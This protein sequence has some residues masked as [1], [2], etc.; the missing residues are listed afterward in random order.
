MLNLEGNDISTVKHSRFMS[1]IENKKDFEQ[2]GHCCQQIT[3]PCLTDKENY[4]TPQKPKRAPRSTAAARSVANLN[5]E[6]KKDQLK[7]QTDSNELLFPCKKKARHKSDLQT[8]EHNEIIVEST[9][10]DNSLVYIE[11]IQLS[12]PIEF[13]EATSPILSLKENSEHIS[14]Y[15]TSIKAQGR[16]RK[17]KPQENKTTRRTSLRLKSN[18][19]LPIQQV[20]TNKSNTK[21]QKKS[22]E[23]NNTDADYEDDDEQLTSSIRTKKKITFSDDK[24]TKKKSHHKMKSV[25]YLKDDSSSEDETSAVVVRSNSR[26][27]KLGASQSNKSVDEGNESEEDQ[28][29][30]LK[31]KNKILPIRP[32]RFSLMN[33]RGS[34]KT[35]QIMTTGIM[36]TDKE[37]NV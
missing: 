7:R 2:N 34:S 9:L 21:K 18:T 5:E 30:S 32:V 24:S 3:P 8:E 23:P 25:N 1:I 6:T 4:S 20:Q 11:E 17:V 10:L 16:P 36:L 29:V 26:T 31:L 15:S 12:Q 14:P 37:K 33:G 19:A 28:L 13:E 22:I 35:P 27:I